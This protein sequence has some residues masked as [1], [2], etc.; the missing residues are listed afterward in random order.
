VLAWA[1]CHGAVA[2]I[3]DWDAR[4]VAQTHEQ[5]VH[6][7][8][9]VVAQAVVQD[10]WTATSASNFVDLM[11]GSGARYPCELAGFEAWARREGLLS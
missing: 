6:G 1:E 3:D 5:E 10:R 11:I 4:R 7:S 2:I 9:W 8:L